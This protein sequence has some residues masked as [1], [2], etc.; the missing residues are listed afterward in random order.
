MM[1]AAHAGAVPADRERGHGAVSGGD[2]ERRVRA[3]ALRM[4][5]ADPTTVEGRLCA[6]IERAAYHEGFEDGKAEGLEEGRREACDD[7]QS[8]EDDPPERPRAA[9][10]AWLGD[11]L[12]DGPRK[13]ANVKACAARDGH[14][15]R[16]VER[17]KADVGAVARPGH[18]GGARA[19]W[20]KLPGQAFPW[21]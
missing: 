1:V 14:A 17:A 6:E 9:A 7:G 13:G 12:R 18:V 16:T 20:W 11:L 5:S 10:A 8:V 15:W 19:S 2:A 21:E 4:R 3:A